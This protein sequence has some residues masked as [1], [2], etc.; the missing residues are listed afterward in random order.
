MGTDNA[1]GSA[2]LAD[3]ALKQTFSAEAHQQSAAPTDK[4]LEATVKAEIAAVERADAS[5]DDHHKLWDRQ[6]AALAG[7]PADAPTMDYGSRPARSIE[8]EY[9]EARTKWEIR[10]DQIIRTQEQERADI[11]AGGQT[12]A[13]T[14]GMAGDMTGDR[15]AAERSAPADA[16]HSAAPDAPEKQ[17]EMSDSFMPRARSTGRS[18]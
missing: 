13:D 8:S 15:P 3:G 14:F 6:R 12:L 2:G 16:D 11:R 18:L 17:A 7:N 1:A 5:M 9:R 10:H 4:S